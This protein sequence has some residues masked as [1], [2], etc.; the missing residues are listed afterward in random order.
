MLDVEEWA[1]QPLGASRRSQLTPD[2]KPIPLITRLGRL[3]CCFAA[4]GSRQKHHSPITTHQTGDLLPTAV[5]RDTAKRSSEKRLA[6]SP[7]MT[8]GGKAS[9]LSVCVGER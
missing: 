7:P 9:M 2:Y 1:Y 8:I 4:D 5:G 3:H 6:V